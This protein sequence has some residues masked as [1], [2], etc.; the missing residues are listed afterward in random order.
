MNTRREQMCWGVFAV[1]ALLLLDVLD[2]AWYGVVVPVAAA[3]LALALHRG[4]EP[5]RWWRSLAAD[6][7]DVAVVLGLYAAIVGLFRLAFVGFGT[8][9][10]AG[11]FVTFAA[12]LLLG[13]V[14]PI[15]YTVWH[16]HRSM[17]SLGLG[18]A[19][20]S[21]AVFGLVLAAVQFSLTLWRQPLP[22]DAEDWLP[23]L[24]MSL[25]VGAFETVFFRGF[26][27]R[28]LEVAFG[29]PV[30]IAVAAG[31]YA[32][33]HVGYGMGADELVFLFGLGVVYAL[34]FAVSGHAV[35]LWPLLTPLGAFY[36]N[37]RSGD[38]DLPWASIA[39][40]VDVLALMALAVWL[41][42]RHERRARR[43]APP[44]LPEGVL[45]STSR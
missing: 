40:F 33:Y 17:S 15:W 30:G 7:R 1:A 37:L 12:G 43:Q 38:I 45:A 5:R 34:V 31:L 6:R 9:R 22:A 21:A 27:Q 19:W 39:G 29:R 10:V 44:T 13:V 25:T 35:V 41:G 23:L 14:A 4:V 11:L 26:A 28:R 20:R 24:V 2:A 32:M 16:R 3:A 18:G 42:H 36:N 8:G